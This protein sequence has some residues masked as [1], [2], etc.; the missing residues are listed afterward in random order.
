MQVPEQFQVEALYVAQPFV[1]A[2]KA[3]ELFVLLLI[4]RVGR[5]LVSFHAVFL[6]FEMNVGV[7]LQVIDQMNSECQI[8]HR[9][10]GG[11]QLLFEKID[12]VDQQPVLLVELWG[13]RLKVGCPNDHN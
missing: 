9:G 1:I 2:D 10:I 3:A 5:T 12:V 6:G 13:T 7:G 4:M 8:L 11:V